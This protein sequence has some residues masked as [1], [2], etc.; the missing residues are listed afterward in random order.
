MMAEIISAVFGVSIGAV[1]VLSS[2]SVRLILIDIFR[3]PLRESQ[4]EV[5]DH[6]GGTKV[7]VL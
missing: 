7:V 5:P 6:E 3:H 1:L 2:R 4:L